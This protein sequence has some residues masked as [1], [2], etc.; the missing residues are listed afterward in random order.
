M[1][2]IHR[3]QACTKYSITAHKDS[4][5]HVTANFLTALHTLSPP[6]RHSFTVLFLQCFLCMLLCSAPWAPQHS[7]ALHRSPGTC[8]TNN[9][10]YWTQ[11]NTAQ[12]SCT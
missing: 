11:Q 6:Y 2:F 1:L 5:K 8:L 4:F 3:L 12:M 9:M 10:S 7:A